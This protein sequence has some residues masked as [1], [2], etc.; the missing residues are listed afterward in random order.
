MPTDSAGGRC[1]DRLHEV[2]WTRPRTV[3]HVFDVAAFLSEHRG[4][5]LD[6]ASTAV[7]ARRLPHYE[8]AGPAETRERLAAL[9]DVVTR[10]AAEKHLEPVLAYTDELARTRQHTGHDLSELQAAINALEE[11]LWRAVLD[12]APPDFQG[13]GLGLVSTILGAVKDRLAC[14]YVARV[15]GQPM[16][17]LRVEELFRGTAG[18]P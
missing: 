11:Q 2:A 18:P 8:A 13:H 3:T 5:I 15:G 9:F 1:V 7:A 14:D 17:S 10:A 16:Q 4:P 12:N 6:R